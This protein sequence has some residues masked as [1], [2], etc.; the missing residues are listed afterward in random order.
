MSEI[1]S[2][3]LL[4]QLLV[5]LV[6][7]AFYALLSLGMAIILGLLNVVNFAHG[8][9]YM[10]GAFGAWLL[11]DSLGLN[12]WVSLVVAPIIVAIIGMALEYTLVRRSYK[13]D[14]LYGLLLTFGMALVIEGLFRERFGVTGHPYSAPPQLQGGQNLGFMFLPNYRVWVLF[15]SIAM[16]IAVWLLLERTRLGSQL[17]AATQNAMLV[18]AFGINVPRIIMLTYG[19]GAGI[20]AFAGVMAAPITH[21][22]SLM[23]SNIVIVVFAVVVVGG[24]GSL[25]GAVV[26]GFLLGLIEGWTKAL[27]PEASSLAI[28]IAMTVVLL[29]RPAGLFG[30]SN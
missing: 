14:P 10:M 17:R 30:K 25:F 26:S 1:I 27:Y 2:P 19:L 4:A 5:G 7:G 6:N 28:F 18:R 15:A 23:G 11:L 9:F 12:Y 8:V 24:M 29:L 20:A 21:V 16:C 3:A 13:L 22:N